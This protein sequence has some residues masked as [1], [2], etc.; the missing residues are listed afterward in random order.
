MIM[1]SKLE[2]EVWRIISILRKR[3]CLI[4]WWASNALEPFATLSM[5]TTYSAKCAVPD[6]WEACDRSQNGMQIHHFDFFVEQWRSGCLRHVDECT[7]LCKIIH[8]CSYSCNDSSHRFRATYGASSRQT[9]E[10]LWLCGMIAL[11]SF[12]VFLFG[13]IQCFRIRLSFLITN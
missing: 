13:R 5:I 3:V 12:L 6:C 1:G 11:F 8:M 9:W 2:W 7:Q 10:W 4:S